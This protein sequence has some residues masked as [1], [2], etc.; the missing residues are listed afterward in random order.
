MPETWRT[1]VGYEGYYEVSDWG[2]VQSLDRV[3][4]GCSGSSRHISGRVLASN[5]SGSGRYPT[6][7]L[8]RENVSSWRAVHDIVLEAFVGP[9]PPG[10]EARHGDDI[11][12]H[13]WLENLSWGTRSDNM[14]DRV[15]NGRHHEAR[16]TECVNRHPFSVANTHIDK[17]GYRSCRKCHAAR[18]RKA[19]YAK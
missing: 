10:M 18:V 6:V 8:W 9:R 15:R 7:T 1:V 2:R 11:P 17:R 5:V 3:V 19:Y 14:H 12:T 4:D 13:L 16:K